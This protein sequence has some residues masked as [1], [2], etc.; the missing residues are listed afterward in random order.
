M[1]NASST[2][3]PRIKSITSLALIGDTLSDFSIALASII[4]PP[5]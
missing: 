2:F 4:S 3:L 5:I 1:F